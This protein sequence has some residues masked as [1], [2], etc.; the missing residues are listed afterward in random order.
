V[1]T[2]GLSGIPLMALS[3]EVLRKAARRVEGS[4]R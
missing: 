1:E 2:G 4:S 3:T